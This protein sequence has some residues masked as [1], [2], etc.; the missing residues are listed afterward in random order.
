MATPGKKGF[1]GDDKPKPEILKI[2]KACEARPAHTGDSLLGRVRRSEPKPAAPDPERLEE[3]LLTQQELARRAQRLPLIEAGMREHG[4]TLEGFRASAA[5]VVPYDEGPSSAYALLH[6][7]ESELHIKLQFVSHELV[8][9][10]KA[11]HQL[12]NELDTSEEGER[13][14]SICGGLD[15]LRG[16][17]RLYQLHYFLIRT[18]VAASKEELA[19]YIREAQKTL[20]L[21]NKIQAECQALKTEN[22]ALR[23]QLSEFVGTDGLALPEPAAPACSTKD[24]EGPRPLSTLYAEMNRFGASYCEKHWGGYDMHAFMDALQEDIDEAQIA[25]YERREEEARAREACIEALYEKLADAEAVG[26]LFPA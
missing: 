17:I 23:A 20:N 24:P 22:Q 3:R 10:R 18:I 11:V 26:L 21:F 14:D 8:Q 12:C 25:L 2:R 16:K 15:R 19:E 9:M 7:P 6:R 13:R 4:Y 5:A 1:G